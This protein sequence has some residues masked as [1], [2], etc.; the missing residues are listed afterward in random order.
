MPP[1]FVKPATAAPAVIVVVEDALLDPSVFT[2]AP[3]VPS[4]V[5]PVLANVVN[6][7]VLG[8]VDPIGG[9]DARSRV[10]ADAKVNGET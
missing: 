2:V 6:A 7:P 3:V 9:G 4:V 1:R 5:L 10:T 8:V